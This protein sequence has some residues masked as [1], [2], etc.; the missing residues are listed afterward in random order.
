MDAV[1]KADSIFAFAGEHG[2][3]LS[4]LITAVGKQPTAQE[5]AL[6]FSNG[7][8]K[9]MSGMAVVMDGEKVGQIVAPTVDSY[10]GDMAYTGR[11]EGR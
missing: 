8:I 3:Q 1:Q 9:G 7:V 4:E 5:T 2:D 10:L 11:F 6:S